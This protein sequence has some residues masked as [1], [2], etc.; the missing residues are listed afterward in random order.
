MQPDAFMHVL[1]RGS[2]FLKHMTLLRFDDQAG[3]SGITRF[4][5]G[6]TRSNRTSRT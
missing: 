3:F 6:V 2:V 4:R 1:D 5:S